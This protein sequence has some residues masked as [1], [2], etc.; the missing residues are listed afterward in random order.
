MTVARRPRR[1]IPGFGLSMGITLS[2]LALFVLI[3]VAALVAKASSMSLE[4][5]VHTVT[6]ARAL[7]SY[8]VSLGAAF[9]AASLNTVFGFVV[10]WVLV[11][12]DF[13]GKR[14]VDTVVDLPFA[15]PTAVGGIA[16]TAVYSSHGILGRAFGAVGIKT[17][18]SFLG[19]VI[20]LTFVTLPFVVRTVEPVL[21]EID[22]EQEEAAA[23]LGAT[24]WLTFRRIIFPALA[25]SLLT[26]FALSFARALGEYGSV[27]FIS[28]NMPKQ[29]EIAPLL[30]MTRLEQFDVA[31]A[32]ALAVV[33]LV[34]SLALLIFINR[35][36]RWATSRGAP[37]P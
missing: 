34:T 36:E 11:R 6:S 35:L 9:A 17:A 7:A 20:A 2:Y 13:W 33:L 14:I 22:A 31:G 24:R 5:F 37:R 12:Y 10:A 28:G 27:V 32:A 18:Y 1:V 26:G 15:L 29:T 8:R 25:P 19:I 23:S 4:T 30:I 21:A 16:L 3:P